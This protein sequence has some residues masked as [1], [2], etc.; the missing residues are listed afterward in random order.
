VGD[1]LPRSSRA[2]HPFVIAPGP[3]PRKMGLLHVAPFSPAR[4]SAMTPDRRQFLSAG[5][6]AVA[7]LLTNQVALADV[8]E[9]ARKFIADHETNV[10]PLEIRAS[11]AWWDAN[12]T[13]KDD[14]FK[15]KEEAQNKIDAALSDK[16]TFGRLKA[17]KEA[18]DKGELADP[19]L[20][21]QIDLLYLAY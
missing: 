13:G 19:L 5:G 18:R 12:I 20:A 4:D 21:R 1:R 17:I 8:T 3:R 2:T 9:D 10:K 15:K 11:I 14:D 6:A 7:G 16:A